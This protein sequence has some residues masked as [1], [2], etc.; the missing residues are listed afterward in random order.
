M[1]YCSRYSKIY[2]YG[3]KGVT[4]LIWHS[5]DAASVINELGSNKENGLGSNEVLSRIARYGKN[6]LHDFEVPSYFKIL[7]SR[8][9]D[10]Y[11]VILFALTLINCIL[12]FATG[13]T[14]PA[15]AIMIMAAVLIN[16]FAGAFITYRNMQKVDRL[17]NSHTTY[18]KV[19]RDGTEQLI[20][21]SNIVPGDIM[22]LASG[23]YIAADGRIID[24]YV[25]ICDEFSVTGETVPIEKNSEDLFE[26]ITPIESRRNMVYAG[27]YV[28]SGK[29]AVVVT[30]TGD[31]SAIGRAES[32]KKTTDTSTTPLLARLTRLDT[33]LKTVTLVAAL[34][35]ALI[36]IFANLKNHEI[37]FAST[38]LS[39][40]ILGLSLTLSAVPEGLPS[41]FKNAVSFSA[42]RLKNRNLTFKSL[43]AA[44]AIGGTSVIC[45]DKTGVLTDD[46]NNLVKI[47]SGKRVVNLLD[48]RLSESDIMLLHLALICSNLKED[49]HIECHS[50]ALELAI[51]RACIKATGMSKADIDGIYP[52]LSEI[53]FDS[54]RMLMTTVT[55]INTKP[56]A[57]IKGAPEIVL[58]RCSDQD[59]D[60]IMKTVDSFADEG[61]KVLAVALKPLDSIPATPTTEELENGLLFVG[62]LG[63]DNPT[64]PMCIKEIAECKRKKIRVVM[65]TGDYKKTAVAV[66]RELGLIEE[67]SEALDHTELS[68]LS[69]EELCYTVKRCSVFA[70]A[71]TE[72]KLR[73]V[74]ALQSSGEQVLLTCDTVSDVSSLKAADFGCALGMTSAESV[75]SAADFIVDDDKFTTLTLA[76]KESNR[77]FDSVLRSIKYAVFGT[78]VE[79]AVLLF[80]III[81]GVSPIT[82]SALIW[83]NLIINLLPS[84]AFSFEAANET[85][86]L[87]RHESRELLTPRSAIGIAVPALVITAL[88]LISYALSAKLG[89]TA[90]TAAAFAVFTVCKTVHAFT[91]SHTYTVFQKGTAK[92]LVMPAACLISLLL[93][94]LTVFTPVGTLFS[95]SSPDF[96]AFGFT[97]VS[98]AIT[99]AVGELIKFISH[100]IKKQHKQSI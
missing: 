18:T 20:P 15:D 11:T 9:K 64:E 75:K 82:A 7:L 29:A 94:L 57:V 8:L 67:D 50:N 38:V 56:Y 48:E 40:L 28:G 10:Y 90:A 79:I 80:G 89:P 96:S 77:V 27:S 16:C 45:T 53:P 19:I 35:V 52:R 41:I 24:S 42:L 25:F 99:L 37:G 6:E 84:L 81:F 51:E 23:D 70:R 12:A 58:S 44:E 5:S 69:D 74:R 98:A 66:G 13:D 54:A 95:L 43:P 73:I 62:L 32:I 34:L 33:V 39:Y 71:S 65:I 60:S 68:A 36:G 55:V 4:V 49:E 46:N 21:S 14:N 63:F 83:F 59:S 93:I 30:E 61:L 17:R 92:N 91:L 78:A 85:L 97:V 100:K 26:S 2:I 1:I 86:S 22:L 3:F 88:S 76:L 31:A 87:R 47:A 72:D